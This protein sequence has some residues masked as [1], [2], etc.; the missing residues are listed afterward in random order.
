MCS[1][2]SRQI[3]TLPYGVQILALVLIA[4]VAEQRG[5]GF[6]NRIMLVQI[7]SSALKIRPGGVADCTGLS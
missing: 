1:W 7:Q 6:V 5:G 3:P 4:D 2:E